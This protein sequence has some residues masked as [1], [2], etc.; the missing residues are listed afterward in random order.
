MTRADDPWVDPAF[1]LGLIAREYWAAIEQSRSTLP[2]FVASF[3]N[4]SKAQ[5]RFLVCG[6]ERQE[7]RLVPVGVLVDRIEQDKIGRL[8]TSLLSTRSSTEADGN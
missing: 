5:S 4:R 6:L 8:P 7:D 3:Q 2:E 1:L